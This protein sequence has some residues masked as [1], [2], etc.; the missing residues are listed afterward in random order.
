MINLILISFWSGV[1]TTIGVI[2]GIIVIYCVY[3]IIAAYFAVKYHY[4]KMQIFKDEKLIVETY[5]PPKKDLKECL[6]DMEEDEKL[7]ITERDP[8]VQHTIGDL[9]KN[10]SCKLDN[11]GLLQL[12]KFEH[13]GKT[14]LT[15]CES[16]TEKSCVMYKLDYYLSHPESDSNNQY[17]KLKQKDWWLMETWRDQNSHNMV[18]SITKTTLPE[19]HID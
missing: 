19:P 14:Y 17:E 10:H 9:Q 8:T 3:Q 7:V 15:I 11:K 18:Y 5:E 2:V 12:V 13:N 16:H 6:M 4:P 1:Q